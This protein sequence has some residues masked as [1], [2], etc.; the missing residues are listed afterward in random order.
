MREAAVSASNPSLGADQRSRLDKS[1]RDHLAGIDP[2]VAQAG[3][4]GVNLLDGSAAGDFATGDGGSGSATLTGFDLTS[5]GPLIGLSADAS[6]TDAGTAGALADQLGGA[7][8]RVQAAVG[9]ITN[10]GAAIQ[11]HLGVLAQASFAASPGG[12]QGLDSTLDQDGARL[13]ALLI[14]QQLGQTGAGLANQAPQSIL[15]LFR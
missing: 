10:Q 8:D 15:A 7:I 13:Q 5:A 2:L 4:G 12:A 11:G 3:V 1:F 9:R 14:Q 6:L